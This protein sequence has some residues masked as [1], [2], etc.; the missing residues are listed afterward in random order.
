M[1]FSLCIFIFQFIES[2][3]VGSISSEKMQPT[4]DDI[5][6]GIL[7]F[8]GQVVTKRSFKQS[9]R[10]NVRAVTDSEFASTLELL[11]RE[12]YGKLVRVRTTLNGSRETFAFVKEDKLPENC[13]LVTEEEFCKQLKLPLHRSIPEVVKNKLQEMQLLS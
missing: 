2:L 11:E 7:L 3:T 10:R 5:K 9:G 8:P 1:W 6:V 12:R 4:V 13:S